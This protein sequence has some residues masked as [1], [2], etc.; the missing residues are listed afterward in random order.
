MTA[1]I[2]HNAPGLFAAGALTLLAFFLAGLSNFMGAASIALLL[3][4]ILSNSKLPS[5][6]VEA[7]LRF[8]EK[9]ILEVAIVLTAFGM[10]MRIFSALG[11][12]TWL[13]IGSSVVMVIAIALLV[14]R[15]FGLSS[16]LGILLGTG[17]A[18]C[19]S[20]AIGAVSPLLHSEEA[21]TGLSV[22]VVNLLS[23]LG[24]LL[25][26]LLTG[27]L[28]LSTEN[29]AL[30]IGGVLQSMGH[31][32]GA[33]YSL[34]AEVGTA[35]MVVKMGRILLIIPL[36]L[37]LFVVN[38]G[39]KTTAK[40][41]RFPFFIPLFVIALILAQMPFLPAELASGLAQSGDYLLVAAMVGIGFKI[42]FKPLIK[43]AG[44]ALAAGL[45]IF[46]FQILLYLFYL[47]SQALLPFFTQR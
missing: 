35:A 9:R 39:K 20:A 45:V 25:L 38:Q 28:G 11:V 33:G 43:M 1:F 37:T 14:G 40:K 26:P 19:G 16:Q 7:G 12:S 36:L 15:W 24:L 32:V 34:G 41:L 23:T 21:E 6:K 30:I 10:N 22:G 29:S 2:K 3:G 17:S 44:P 5:K 46:A 31:V 13:F 47:N 8:T 42:K 4:L 18:I 27:F